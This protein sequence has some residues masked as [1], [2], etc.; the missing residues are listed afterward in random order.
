MFLYDRKMTT[1]ALPGWALV[2][3]VIAV[4]LLAA[5]VSSAAAPTPTPTEPVP[6][7]TPLPPTPTPEPPTATP[8][9]PTPTPEPP[10][11]TPEPPTPTPE[12]PTAT[13][14][15]P[16]STPEPPEATPASESSAGTVNFD[17]IFPPGHEQ[18]RDLVINSCGNC[19]SWVCPVIGQRPVDHWTTVKATH[20]DFVST[21]SDEDYDLLF[22]FLAENFNDTKPLPDLPEALE[23]LGCTTQQ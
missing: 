12:P 7:A 20:R 23:S 10:T 22:S 16:T 2:S 21:M 1:V 19:H 8:E 13:S 17:E 4:L 14:E 5:C 11:A 15:P 6:N 3:L 9:P 18:Q